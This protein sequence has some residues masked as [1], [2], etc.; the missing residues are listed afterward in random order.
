MSAELQQENRIAADTFVKSIRSDGIPRNERAL[1]TDLDGTFLHNHMR[2]IDGF[3]RLFPSVRKGLDSIQPFVGGVHV[4]TRR[5]ADS[6]TRSLSLVDLERLIPPVEPGSADESIRSKLFV[7]LL[8]TQAGRMEYGNSGVRFLPDEV[9]IQRLSYDARS[10]ILHEAAQMV[11]RGNGS[12]TLIYPAISG[13][14][15]VHDSLAWNDIGRMLQ[16]GET[17]PISS[18]VLPGLPVY[19]EDAL[20]N[21][22]TVPAM[23][24]LD[25]IDRNTDKIIPQGNSDKLP[26]NVSKDRWANQLISLYSYDPYGVM[27][28]GD[29]PTQ[30]LFLYNKIGGLSGIVGERDFSFDKEYGSVATTRLRDP[31]EAGLFLSYIGEEL[32]KQFI[33]PVAGIS[34]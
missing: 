18:L 20:H 19:L 32:S 11:M 27:I 29:D 33:F 8:G 3:I 7:T 15:I 25:E 12:R 23:V 14:E 24:V 6:L 31:E 2:S 9:H 28:F 16:L 26:E 34:K 4:V 17:Y 10:E 21:P 30:Y 13:K 22:S 1:I 5:P